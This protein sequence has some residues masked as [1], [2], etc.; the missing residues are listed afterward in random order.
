MGPMRIVSINVGRAESI[1]HKRRQFVTGIDKQ[2]TGRRTA[3]L[4]DGLEADVIC[5]E[6][7]H[8][9]RDQ[10]VYVYAA[11]D[12]A[13]WSDKLGRPLR[14]GTFGDNLTIAGMPDDLHAGDRLLI[15]DVLLEAT[16]PRIPC[17]T[18]AAR[19]RDSNFGLRFRRAGRPGFYFRVLSEGELAA[20]DSVT[21]VAGPAG[22]VTMLELFR[23]S[24]VTKP[25]AA[26]L[27]RAIAAPIAER[28]RRSFERKLSAAR[29]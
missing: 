14:P 26:D 21:L 17:S 19:M 8:G 11:E 15:G 29:R 7:H 25:A 1:A 3:L 9:G 4:V 6:E 10:A 5:D 18:L 23:L 20:G 16:A 27:E 12:Y 24:Y 28:M 2:P 22:N 13:W